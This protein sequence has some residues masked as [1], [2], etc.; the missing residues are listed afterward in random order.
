MPEQTPQTPAL[1]PEL[2]EAIRVIVREE[3]ARL[4]DPTLAE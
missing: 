2:I 1:P 4:S 3:F